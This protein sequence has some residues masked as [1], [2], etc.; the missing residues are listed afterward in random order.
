MKKTLCSALRYIAHQNGCDLVF[1]SVKEKLPSQ[2]YR[3]LLMDHL[4]EKAAST[5]PDFNS[6]NPIN[7]RAGQDKLSNIGEPQ[8]AGQS[9]KSLESIW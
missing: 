3:T 4:F 1:G 7:V 2:L 9:R 8:G 5:D 6:Q